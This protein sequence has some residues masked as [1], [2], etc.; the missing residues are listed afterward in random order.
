MTTRYDSGRLGVDSVLELSR[1][2][3][4][5]GWVICETWSTSIK[6]DFWK[7]S[8]PVINLT[9]VRINLHLMRSPTEII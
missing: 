7:A 9:R 6:S 8:E 1:G 2:P 4:N 3:V 5:Q